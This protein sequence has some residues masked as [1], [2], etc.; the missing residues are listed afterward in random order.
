MPVEPNGPPPESRL[1]EAELL[2]LV[3]RAVR[4]RDNTTLQVERGDVVAKF[5][6]AGFSWRQIE[7][8]TG[9]PI[10]SAHRWWK[11]HTGQ[12]PDTD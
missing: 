10:A 5:R 11:A 7:D 9:I 8:L 3:E 2:E 6:R 12:E 1:S 4:V